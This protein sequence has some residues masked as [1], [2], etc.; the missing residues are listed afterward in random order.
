MPE[1]YIYAAD[2]RTV[3]Q[4]RML[5]REVDR[6]RD[7]QLQCPAGGGGRAIRHLATPIRRRAGGVLFSDKAAPRSLHAERDHGPMIGVIGL[8]V[9]GM[10][11]ARNMMAAGLDVVG[12][13]IDA[14]AMA[15][16]AASGGQ[17]A[18]CARD[19]GDRCEVVLTLLPSIAALDEVIAGPGG[20]CEVR[21]RHTG[22]R[23]MQHVAD[24]D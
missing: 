10:P 16:F 13:D 12:F 14:R 21:V 5:A 3:D 23:R 11:I 24:R 8:G 15:A 2:G 9:M 22:G 20:L 17:P 4:K 7:P 18:A 1:I 6:R 19:V